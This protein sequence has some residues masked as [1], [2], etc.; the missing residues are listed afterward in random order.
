MDDDSLYSYLFSNTSEADC[1]YT[2]QETSQGTLNICDHQI[3]SNFCK[4]DPLR[5]L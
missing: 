5:E 3:V 1:I 2:A 4:R